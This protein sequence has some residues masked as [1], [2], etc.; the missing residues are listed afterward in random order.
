MALTLEEVKTELRDNLDA[1]REAISGETADKFETVDKS[2][3]DIQAE[4]NQKQAAGEAPDA[5]EVQDLQERM[6]VSEVEL[7]E[8]KEAARLAIAQP[9]I[10][11]NKEDVSF[12][13]KFLKDWDAI[14][15]IMRQGGYAQSRAIDAA[16]I[17]SAGLLTPQQADAF[18]DFVIAQQVGIGLATTVR[19]MSPQGYTEELRLAS[20]KMIAAAE[21]TAPDVANAITA[22]RR[23]MTTVEVIWAEDLTLTFLEDNIERRGAEGHIARLIGTG[24]GNDSNDLAWNG[25]ASSSDAFVGINNGWI[26]LALA[27]SD[28]NDVTSYGSAIDTATEVLGLLWKSVPTK[29]LGRTDYVYFTPVVFA[30]NYAEE[31]STRL[32]GLGDEVLVNGFPA[33]RYFG[34]RIVPD[35]HLAAG[36]G[37]IVV[38]PT[39]NLHFGIQRAITVDSEW[40]ARKRVVEYTITART[41]YEYA[42]GE[43]IVLAA[44]LTV[45]MS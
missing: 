2:I 25:D 26:T 11:Q 19:L 20:R 17:A 21:A 22:A 4:L 28:V 12:K 9:T 5:E 41:D 33:L 44:N 35:T 37:Y 10:P 23:T 40:N 34:K 32:T 39:V 8:I 42:T 6:D 36:S 7:A 13:G 31:V 43:A 29:F 1:V 24:F 45:A 27:D 30:Q 38:T 3:K 14:R 18:I 15:N 16:V